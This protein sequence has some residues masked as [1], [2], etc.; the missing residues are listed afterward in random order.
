[1]AAGAAAARGFLTTIM[2]RREPNARRDSRKARRQASDA[3]SGRAAEPPAGEAPA[4]KVVAQGVTDQGRVRKNNEDNLAAC[5]LSTGETF[6]GPF[7][8]Q[9]RQGP[10][11]T[12]LLVADGMGGEACG[13]LASRMCSELLPKQLLEDLEGRQSPSRAEFGS[14]LCHAVEA[15]SDAILNQS[16]AELSSCQGMGTTATAAALYGVHLLVAQVGDSRAYLIRN[17]HLLQLTRDQTFL[18]YLIDM[19]AAEP[20]TES[21]K[22]PRKSILVQAVGATEKLHVALTG[23]ELRRGDR[24]VLA[25]DGL[26]NMVKPEDILGIAS[27]DGSLAARCQKFIQAANSAGGTDNITVILAELSGPGLPL[28]NP[29]ASLH[30]ETLGTQAPGSVGRPNAPKF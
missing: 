18:N 26:S 14:L 5:D 16:R 1:L 21:A 30:V 2:R 22:D 11:G 28:P 29:A 19:G 25:S 24:L 23:L 3:V 8:F 17:G 12:L 4:V 27:L 7:E 9:R 20:G 13:E 10:F 15:A 6:A